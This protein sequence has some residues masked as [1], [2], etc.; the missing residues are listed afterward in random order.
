MHY[1]E[2]KFGKE[3]VIVQLS[4]GK[5]A[6]SSIF[7]NVIDMCRLAVLN[8]LSRLHQA[9]RRDMSRTIILTAAV[10]VLAG[11]LASNALARNGNQEKKHTHIDRGPADPAR[12]VHRIAPDR[13]EC[14]KIP[15]P[16]VTLGHGVTL[17]IN[18]WGP[19]P[20]AWPYAH[21]WSHSGSPCDRACNLPTSPCWNQDRE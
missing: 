16:V 5:Q 10:L 20:P 17:V 9:K 8:P 2:G 18:D 1:G 15:H 4:S 19:P 12:E 6:L 7:Q 14:R 11:A 21:V 13:P 3:Q